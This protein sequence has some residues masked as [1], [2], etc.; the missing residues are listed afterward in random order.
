MTIRHI[1]KRCLFSNTQY[2][3]IIETNYLF[4]SFRS[5]LIS[6]IDKS[7]NI[8]LAN[9][10]YALGI[11]EIGLSRAKLIC[12]KYSN[13][14]DRIRNLTEEELSEIEGVGEVIAKEWVTT[15]SND[16]FINELEDVLKEINFIDSD[17]NNVLKLKDKIFVITGSLEHFKNRDE[18]VEFIENMGGKV[19]NSISKKTSYLIN[20][21]ITS[22]SSKNTKAKELGVEIINEDY[23]LE[24]VK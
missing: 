16:K 9:F 6:S 22:T 21:D 5:R 11:P 2:Y 17:N 19:V 23:L 3:K 8:K 24:L 10:I 12:R 18:L 4:N 14:F 13:D 1:K 20:N 15:F 7:R